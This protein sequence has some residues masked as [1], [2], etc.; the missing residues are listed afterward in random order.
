MK[1]NKYKIKIREININNNFIIKSFDNREF[2]SEIFR[3]SV[4]F[5]LYNKSGN[6][7]PIS[8][9][10][11][12]QFAKIYGFETKNQNIIINK[13]IIPDN[14]ILLSDSSEDFMDI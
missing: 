13:I 7:V 12:N 11:E 4:K 10:E 8:N 14:Y 3:G 5:K 6:E 1:L 9:L 2:I